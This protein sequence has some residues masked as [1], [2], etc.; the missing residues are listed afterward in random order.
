MP[1]FYE[2]NIVE[3][4]DEYTTFLINILT[5]QIYTG[6]KQIYDAS[7]TKREEIKAEIAKGVAEGKYG[8]GTK[9]P[10]TL[11]IFQIYLRGVPGWN[12]HTVTK[13]TDRIRSQSRC[14]DWFDDLVKAVVKSYIVLLTFSATE[15][16]C[17]VVKQR[18]HE[19][20]T[21]ED[22]IHKVYIQA[23]HSFYNFPE[24]FWH[25][26]DPL[27]LK[28]N[29]RDILTMIKEAIRE[30]IRK[31]LPM[32]LVLQEFLKND[33]IKDEQVTN[34]EYDVT[35][36][37][38][39]NICSMVDRDINPENPI[40]QPE[41]RSP[42]HE[43]AK[44]VDQLT[45]QLES[46]NTQ[47]R[48]DPTGS[49]SPRVSHQNEPP[50]EQLNNGVS[51]N[52]KSSYRIVEDPEKRGSDERRRSDERDGGR[53]TSDRRIS[54]ERTHDRERDHERDHGRDQEKENVINSDRKKEDHEHRSHQEPFEK[55][56]SVGHNEVKD[57]DIERS[58]YFA[59]YM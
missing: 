36:S 51:D 40:N 53:K 45:N 27:E 9:A 31:L 52:H 46:L 44:T 10:T 3:I 57:T 54:D 7:L 20:V 14:A 21:T 48:Q 37:H 35:D 19:R 1:H 38:Y 11:R 23:A 15:K 18:I 13:E 59:N 30:A 56:E 32:K 47:I 6:I 39:V 43:A 34:I 8:T 33:Y 16:Q 55:A 26:Y 22:L 41:L 17:S 5:P 50:H 42:I 12:K 49:Y 29:Q 25:Q 4:R 58:V 2:R 24:I 28:R